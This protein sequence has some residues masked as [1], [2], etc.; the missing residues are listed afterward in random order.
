M[1]T[2]TRDNTTTTTA[3]ATMPHAPLWVAGAIQ[4]DAELAGDS[5][6]QREAQDI[7]ITTNTATAIT[8]TSIRNKT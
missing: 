3:T 2:T 6:H 5:T 7:H 1:V 8:I 4:E